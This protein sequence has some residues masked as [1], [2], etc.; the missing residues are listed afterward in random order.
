MWHVH[1]NLLNN[2]KKEQTFKSYYVSINIY[3]NSTLKY[4]T[5]NNHF[6]NKL[7]FHFIT[8]PDPDIHHS[9]AT[10]DIPRNP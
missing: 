2:Q 7:F 9:G 1:I 10:V 6:E 5:G 3:W 8:D 4:L